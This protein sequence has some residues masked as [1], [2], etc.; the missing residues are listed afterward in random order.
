MLL[1]A[2]TLG[3]ALV[4]PGAAAAKSPPAQDAVAFTGGPALVS[5]LFEIFAIDARSGPNGESPS[6][7]VRF[8]VAGGL[9]RIGGPV[10]CLAVRGDSATIN[11][12]DE[13]G[14]FGIVTVQL[15]DGQP[16][17]FDS[18]PTG[19]PPADCSPL[20][21][22]GAGGRPSQGDIAIVDAPARP[23]SKDRCRDGGWRAL[24]FPNQG[25]CVAAAR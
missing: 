4:L 20:A 8:D 3:C 22:T 6:G 19:R 15:F 1:A 7:Y 11:L 12:R 18:A 16:D 5:E 9:F 10:T 17:S 13:V 25:R 21:P 14:G 2:V 24:G 23:A